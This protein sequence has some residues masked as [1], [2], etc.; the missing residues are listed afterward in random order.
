MEGDTLTVRISGLD[1]DWVA[2][3]LQVHGGR[4]GMPVLSMKRV[5]IC[6]N[7]NARV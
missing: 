2:I 5:L 3:T 6:L 1:P 7:K 4:Y